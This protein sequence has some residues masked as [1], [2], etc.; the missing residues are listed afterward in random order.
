MFTMPQVIIQLNAG[1][2]SGSLGRSL[3]VLDTLLKEQTL[4]GWDQLK[5]EQQRVIRS[6]RGWTYVRSLKKMR[7]V[8]LLRR[9][10]RSGV[11]AVA[12]T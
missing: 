12:D 10:A 3:L 11:E 6:C 7:L 9:G 5:G 8:S 1:V 2:A 4:R